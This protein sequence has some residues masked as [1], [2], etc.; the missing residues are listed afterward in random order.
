VGP[1]GGDTF[2]ARFG[3]RPAPTDYTGTAVTLPGGVYTGT[4]VAPPAAAAPIDTFADRFGGR[5]Q[6]L[7]SDLVS[8]TPIGT[9]QVG[10]TGVPGQPG[11]RG[12]EAATPYALPGSIAAPDVVGARGTIAPEDAARLMFDPTLMGPPQ[13][14]GAP[15]PAA[16]GIRGTAPAPVEPTP[17]ERTGRA[18]LGAGPG[19]RLTPNEIVADRFSTLPFATPQQQPT[20]QL[21]VQPPGP[22]AP[23]NVP[24]PPPRPDTAQPPLMTTR[25]T[26]DIPP[27]PPNAPPMM[28]PTAPP[29]AP[30]PSS[31]APPIGP[32]PAPVP[33][34]AVPTD[35]EGRPIMVPP[36]MPG[37]GGVP[38]TAGLGPGPYYPPSYFAGDPNQG[39]T[40]MI[41]QFVQSDPRA[42][43][44]QMQSD[45]SAGP[46]L[47]AQFTPPQLWDMFDQIGWSRGEQNPQP[48]P[49]MFPPGM[50]PMMPMG[51]MGMGGMGMGRQ[52][53]HG[54]YVDQPGYYQRGGLGVPQMNTMAS[55]AHYSAINMRPAI[56]RP[57]GIHLMASSSIPGRTDRIP[58]RARPGSYVL[59]ADVVSGLGQGNTHA[60]ARMWGQAIMA[61]VPGAGTMGGLRRGS[62]PKPPGMPGLGRPARGLADGG[63]VDDEYVPI[64][65][66]GGEVLIDPEVV[67]ALGNGSELLGKR[68]LAESVLKVR[69]QT[70]DHLKKLPR[71]VA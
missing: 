50:M 32:V 64:I 53:A 3:A 17:V 21:Q 11:I 70:I 47:R 31:A 10:F 66:A 48:P 42:A 12:T 68:K 25:P 69:K 37:P 15:Y 44:A 67:E 5:A 71:P 23:P 35:R 19:G 63:S 45:P 58:M 59:P 9:P 49:S 41:R 57:P 30:P 56:G 20:S 52:F 24:L 7:P 62:M 8:P 34:Q 14:F 26:P 61:S 2:D 40:Q 39:A 60:G 16:P 38:P 4:T 6:F 29:T 55:Q 27:V 51:G 33:P 54:G 28:Q 18:D 65:T 1:T 22:Y 46:A 43:A 36:G 13:T